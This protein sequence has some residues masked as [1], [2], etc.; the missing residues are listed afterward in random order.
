M[1]GLYRA[2]TA[3]EL[4]GLLEHLPLG[5]WLRW[6]VTPLESHPNDPAVVA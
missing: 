3:A 2:G 5:D 6:S 1:V 4:D